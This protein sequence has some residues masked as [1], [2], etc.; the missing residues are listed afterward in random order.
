M[1]EMLALRWS[2]AD[3]E[4]GVVYI[5]RTVSGKGYNEPKTASGS[6]QIL[7]DKDTIAMLKEH[8]KGQL[9]EKLCSGNQNYN[10]ENLISVTRNGRRPPSP[11]LMSLLLRHARTRDFQRSGSTI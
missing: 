9:Q 4:K 5:K 10:L 6:R 3:F 1:G 11:V 7:I 2:D 8:R